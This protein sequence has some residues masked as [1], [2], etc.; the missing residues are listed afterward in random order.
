M[1]LFHHQAEIDSFFHQLDFRNARS[2][3]LL[4]ARRC[5]IVGVPGKPGE[6]ELFVNEK[7]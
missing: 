6:F 4:C 1:I 2:L 5:K 3:E 7:P